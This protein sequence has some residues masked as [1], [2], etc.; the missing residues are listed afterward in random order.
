MLNVIGPFGRRTPTERGRKVSPGPT[1]GAAQPIYITDHHKH[2]GR[3]IP[4]PGP[5]SARWEKIDAMEINSGRGLRKLSRL[6]E[7]APG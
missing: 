7:T 6:I 3:N 4:A 2:S 1:A 5:S